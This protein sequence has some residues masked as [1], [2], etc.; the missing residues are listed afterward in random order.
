MN[1]NS[2]E[3]KGYTTIKVEKKILFELR[4]DIL[5]SLYNKILKKKILINKKNILHKYLEISRHVNKL[6]QDLFLENFGDVS[7]R[8]C[9]FRI[10]SII[11]AWVVNFAKK[12]LGFNEY[13][14]PYPMKYQI[15]ENNNI[16]KRQY[17]IYFRCVRSKKKDVGYIHR[18]VDFWKIEKP[19]IPKKVKNYKKLYKIWIPVFGCTK[20]NSLT[21][22]EKSQ[23]YNF[24]IRYI[25]KK[26][27]KPMIDNTEANL[28]KK[29]V[30]INDFYNE[31]V[32]FDYSTAHYAPINKSKNF[33]VSAEFTII[34]K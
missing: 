25:K 24:N 4:K 16:K 2:L 33:R 18:D 32:V 22:L 9:S 6:D 12:K 11:N 8:Y 31:A 5:G 23:N 19:L 1:I 15:K 10:G 7:L 26:F 13:S 14:L 21:I 30:P 29:V 3:E 28:F 27:M 20:K 17:C 34:C